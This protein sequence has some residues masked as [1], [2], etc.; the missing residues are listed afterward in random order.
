MT[1]EVQCQQA[2]RQVCG[3]AKGAANVALVEI[4]RGPYLVLP[5]WEAFDAGE[6]PI[7]VHASNIVWVDPPGVTSSAYGTK[8]AYL[9][10]SLQE[11]Q[12]NGVLIKLPAGF[13]G[14]IH[15]K[16]STFRAV[17]VKGRPHYQGDDLKTL[18]PGSYFD[19]RGE[20]VHQVA[21]P[22]GEESVIYVRTDGKYE[23]IP[24]K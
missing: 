3:A 17:V 23:I 2:F 6:R 20:T 18:E 16:S 9:W 4:D 11:G 24:V 5:A 14:K 13:T 22:A 12:S 10:G 19:S 7:N 21:S 1:A 15:S 8:V